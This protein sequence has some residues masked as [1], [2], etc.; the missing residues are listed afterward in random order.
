MDGLFPT[1]VYML[2]FVTSSA[3]AY[4]LG[5]SYSKTGA[6]LLLWS[7]LCFFF[8]AINNLFLVIDLVF[9]PVDL[10]LRFARL[11]MALIAVCVL[12][13]GFVWDLEED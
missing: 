7:A 11:V 3:C 9:L 1:I 8:L 13:F 5:R 4:L 2:C 10:D 6:R 12:L